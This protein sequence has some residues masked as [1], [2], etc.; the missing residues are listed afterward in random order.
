MTGAHAENLNKFLAK[1]PVDQTSKYTDNDPFPFG[2]YKGVKMANVPATY[3]LWLEGEILH[4]A[5]NKR[6]L[7]HKF[8]LTY[9]EENRN[10]LNTEK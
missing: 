5:P 9:I 1:L 10:V 4:A 6:S 7:T 2:K 8:L 3:L